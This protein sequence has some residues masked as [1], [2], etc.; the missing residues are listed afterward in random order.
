MLKRIIGI[1]SSLG[2]FGDGLRKNKPIKIITHDG[3][4]HADDVFA[5]AALRIYFENKNQNIEIIRSRDPEVLKT[6]DITLDVGTAYDPEKKLF[7]HHQ[8]GGAG[9][10][11]NGIPYASAGLIWKQYGAEVAGGNREQDLIDEK[12]IQSIDLSDTGY[13]EYKS[14]KGHYLYSLGSL[15]GV[16]NP[17]GSEQ[18]PGD[19]KNMQN[20]LE[21][22]A[23]A[24]RILEREIL[25]TK[26][27]VADEIEA[28]EIYNKTE[29]KRIIVIDKKI[30]WMRTYCKKPE[31]IYV[32]QT[33]Y[34]DSYAI[35]AVPTEPDS[36]ENRKPFPESWRGKVEEELEKETG[37]K[38]AKFCHLK[39]FLCT[40]EN[41][42]SAIAM[43]QKA[44]EFD[45]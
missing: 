22:V 11:E 30:S 7:D 21:A 33:K 25:K 35:R 6:A 19:D 23:I 18:I 45:E 1:I 42:E 29:D 16:F 27:S 38:G 5:C 28:E 37:I 32:V 15:F 31:P 36:H 20:F 13:D 24:K 43:A 34:G 10:R 3:R 39:G 14:P 12:L 26:I 40:A 17:I 41:R 44:L 9:E 2:V 4:F 8:V